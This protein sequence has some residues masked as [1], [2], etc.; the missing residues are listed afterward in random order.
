[1]T[2]SHILHDALAKLMTEQRN[3]S[4]M[5][6]DTRST[7]GILRLINAVEEALSLFFL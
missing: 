6:L 4:S 5:D 3:P 1:M 2:D 7:E